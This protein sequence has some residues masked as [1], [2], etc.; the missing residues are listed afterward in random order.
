M[1]DESDKTIYITGKA[2]TWFC[3]SYN[4]NKGIAMKYSKLSVALLAAIG[5]SACERTVVT[6]PVSS[7]GPVVV[8]S[9]PVI[10]PTPVPVPGPPGPQGKAGSEGMPGTP[11]LEGTPGPKGEPGKS[12]DTVVI[13]PVP[14]KR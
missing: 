9:T 11:G 1:S 12:R 5:L 2:Y 14:E 13:V 10:V 3:N 8:P 6:P 4:R 7:P